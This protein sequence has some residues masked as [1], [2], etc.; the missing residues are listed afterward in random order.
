MTVQPGTMGYKVAG[1]WQLYGNLLVLFKIFP[2]TRV[3]PLNHKVLGAYIT[4]IP[5]TVSITF[6]VET[7]LV[8]V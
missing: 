7:V 2:A 4:I 5:F 3:Y 8:V 1:T 6:K